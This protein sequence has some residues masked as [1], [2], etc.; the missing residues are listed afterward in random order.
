MQILRPRG[1]SV[2]VAWTTQVF[3]ILSRNLPEGVKLDLGRTPEIYSG[4]ALE[5]AR[6]I[7]ADQVLEVRG[8][9]S[10]PFSLFILINAY[11]PLSLTAPFKDR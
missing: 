5:L 4:L 2:A 6:R 11:Y 1:T 10:G 3:S 7:T 8:E 9:P